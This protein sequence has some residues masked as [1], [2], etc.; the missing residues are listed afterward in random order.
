MS[1]LE[2]IEQ[3]RK[4]QVEKHGFTSKHDDQYG[5]FE[6]L[7]AAK[8]CITGNAKDWPNDWGS[9]F[10]KKIDGKSYNQKLIVAAAF[11]VA[12]LERTTRASAGMETNIPYDKHSIGYFLYNC[13]HP[14]S[15]NLLDCAI[16]MKVDNIIVSDFR[17]ALD[18]LVYT[19]EQTP[20]NDYFKLSAF[21]SAYKS[22]LLGD[23]DKQYKFL[24]RHL[25]KVK[26]LQKDY[27]LENIEKMVK[28]LCTTTC[29]TNLPAQIKDAISDYKKLIN[30]KS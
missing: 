2:L 26:E 17:H 4:E 27:A 18:S 20:H 28:D 7:R 8:Y 1:V 3:E 22:G 12:E 21:A 15:S 30:Q 25:D 9:S 5:Q 19:A 24:N 16:E 23:L 6:L 14:Y 13:E 11:L 10:R 29:T